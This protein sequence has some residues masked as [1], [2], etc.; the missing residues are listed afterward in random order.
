MGR[1]ERLG[2]RTTEL[3]VYLDSSDR[4]SAKDD[5]R[6][7]GS[8]HSDYG[9]MIQSLLD[10]PE[11]E[12]HVSCAVDKQPLN[13]RTPSSYSQTPCTLTITVYGPFELFEPIGTW[14]QEYDV[15]L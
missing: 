1:V 5:P 8:I 7:H 12:L 14:F 4:F 2:P 13:H 10:E 15:Y 3:T 6:C 11:L 9:Q